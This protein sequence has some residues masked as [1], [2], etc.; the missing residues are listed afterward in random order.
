MSKQKSFQQFDANWFKERVSVLG[1]SQ[2]SIAKKVGINQS[3]I[4]HM[5]TGRRKVP[6]EEMRKWQQVLGVPMNIVIER[7]GVEIPS[8]LLSSGAFKA[9]HVRTLLDQEILEAEAHVK[10]LKQIRDGVMTA[11]EEIFS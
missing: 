10:R 11:A 1:I 6:F 2:R 3:S 8:E 5:L 9:R 7:F 4:T